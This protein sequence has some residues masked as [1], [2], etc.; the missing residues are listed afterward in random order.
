MTH[1]LTRSQILAGVCRLLSALAADP[2]LAPVLAMVLSLPL[3]SALFAA[4]EVMRRAPRSYRAR[5]LLREYDTAIAAEGLCW[6][7]VI[8]WRADQ[9]RA[10]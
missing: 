8:A 2:R 7:D 10:L 6:R 9:R 3:H 1:L 5:R 4:E